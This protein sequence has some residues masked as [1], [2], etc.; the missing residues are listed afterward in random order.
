MKLSKRRHPEAPNESLAQNKYY[1]LAK[2]SPDHY[3]DTLLFPRDLG[4]EPARTLL[5]VTRTYSSIS[6][7]D[8]DE[9]NTVFVPTRYPWRWHL[10]RHLVVGLVALWPRIGF[11][12]QSLIFHAGDSF[13]GPMVLATPSKLLLPTLPVS[14]DSADCSTLVKPISGLM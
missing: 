14:L 3:L 7:A 5:F 9:T 4:I 12:T 8:T 2:A 10:H 13:G 1:Q 6:A 11:S